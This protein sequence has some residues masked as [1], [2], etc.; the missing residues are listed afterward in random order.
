MH[1]DMTQKNLQLV[2]KNN[3]ENRITYHFKP[4]LGQNPQYYKLPG[5]IV[6]A[7]QVEEAAMNRFIFCKSFLEPVIG[8]P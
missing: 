3:T 1:S 5:V 4:L 8:I 6:V 7:V 2:S